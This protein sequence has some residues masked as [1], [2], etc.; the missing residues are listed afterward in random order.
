MP[1]VPS[2]C[3]PSNENRITRTGSYPPEDVA[4]IELALNHKRDLTALGSA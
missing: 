3:R 1:K 2:E 4:A